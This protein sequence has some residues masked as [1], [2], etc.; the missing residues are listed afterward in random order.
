MAHFVLTVLT[1]M[2]VLILVGY[3]LAHFGFVVLLLVAFG[4]LGRYLRR[5]GA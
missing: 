5:Q 2:L 3:A 1:I 4:L